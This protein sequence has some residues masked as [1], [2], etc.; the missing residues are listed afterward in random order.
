MKAFTL[1]YRGRRASGKFSWRQLH[2]RNRRALRALLLNGNNGYILN[3]PLP[4]H[5][6]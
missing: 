6:R 5:A 4:A 1:D 2:S 3:P